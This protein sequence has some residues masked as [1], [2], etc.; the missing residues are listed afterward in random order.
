MQKRLSI[1]YH[2]AGLTILLNL[3]ILSCVAVI[4]G[5]I[6]AQVIDESMSEYVMALADS[7]ASMPVIQETL[8]NRTP[9]DNLFNQLLKNYELKP[10]LAIW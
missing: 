2:I 8:F 10:T 1:K 4:S 3:F 5:N 7:T 6:S 9:P